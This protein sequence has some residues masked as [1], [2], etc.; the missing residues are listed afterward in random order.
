MDKESILKIVRK[1]EDS[2]SFMA[3][4]LKAGVCI[5]CGSDNTKTDSSHP[6][7]NELECLDCGNIYYD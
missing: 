5:K 6:L 7:F 1:K 2:D 4:C 3:R